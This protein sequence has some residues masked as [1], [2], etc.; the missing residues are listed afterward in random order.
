MRPK[1]SN[2]SFLG[3]I[4]LI[5]RAGFIGRRSS[6]FIIKTSRSQRVRIASSH[7]EGKAWQWFRGVEHSG[8]IDG[9]QVFTQVLNARFSIEASENTVGLLKKLLQ[10]S[11]AQDY[12]DQSEKLANETE[13]LTVQCKVQRLYLL[14]GSQVEDEVLEQEAEQI[15]KETGDL[16]VLQAEYSDSPEILLHA[17]SG[18]LG[19][20]TM[21]LKGTISRHPVIVR[22]RKHP[23]LP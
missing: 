1:Q 5:R 20:Q 22:F 15:K 14:D 23:H 21:R 7:L 11:N 16:Q 3:L 10:T 17:I 4:A 13:G 8:T 18:T 9:W 19:P 12:Q 2:G 6:F